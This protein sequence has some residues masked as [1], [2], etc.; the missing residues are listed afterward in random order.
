MKNALLI[1]LFMTTMNVVWSQSSKVNTAVIKTE[2]ACD[3]CS[4]CESCDQNIF[5]KIKENTKGVKS[6]KI[7]S[8]TNTVTVKYS[9]KKTN[10]EEIE[11]AITMAGYKAND[12]V[13]TNEAYEALDGCC[14]RK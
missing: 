5:M 3:H 4:V 8:E 1:A 11:K 12:Q 10:L 2:I 7:D 9:T 13:P 6:V 14:K